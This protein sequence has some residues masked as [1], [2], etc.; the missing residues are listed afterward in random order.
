M[1]RKDEWV[2]I[3]EASP[4]FMLYLWRN[5]V[6]LW[7]WNFRAMVFLISNA[8]RNL[9]MQISPSHSK[10]KACLEGFCNVPARFLIMRTSVATLN[11]IQI[12]TSLG[13]ERCT[14]ERCTWTEETHLTVFSNHWILRISPKLC[15]QIPVWRHLLRGVFQYQQMLLWMMTLHVIVAW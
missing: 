14:W 2:W 11:L 3:G 9:K 8:S 10:L 5:L 12:S 7:R 1:L 15:H 13:V 4:S 6:A